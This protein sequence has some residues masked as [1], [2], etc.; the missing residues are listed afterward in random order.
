MDPTLVWG[1]LRRSHG[2][3]IAA[4][5]PCL[6]NFALRRTQRAE[7]APTSHA[8]AIISFETTNDFW[9]SKLICVIEPCGRLLT[10][11]DKENSSFSLFGSVVPLPPATSQMEKEFIQRWR[12]L[13][14]AAL[15][16]LLPPL[17]QTASLWSQRSTRSSLMASAHFGQSHSTFWCMGHE[18]FKH[19][20]TVDSSLL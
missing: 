17:H 1:T 18:R 16:V 10:D 4:P 3:Q 13:R 9:N 7:Y 8:L 11:S 6:R 19:S 15:R 12:R 5:A 20:G 14:R 2:R